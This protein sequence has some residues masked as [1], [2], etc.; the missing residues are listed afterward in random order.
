MLSQAYGIMNRMGTES[1]R[2]KTRYSTEETGASGDDVETGRI[3]IKRSPSGSAP[4]GTPEEL[5]TAYEAFENDVRNPSADANR[6][7]L[8]SLF[9]DKGDPRRPPEWFGRGLLYTAI[10]VFSAIFVWNGWARIQLIVTYVLIAVFI[11]LAVEPVVLWLI[12]HGWKRSVASVTALLSV[13]LITCAMLVLFGQMFVQQLMSMF[14]NLPSLYMQ[15]SSDIE[16]QFHFAMPEIDDL[17]SEA[18]AFIKKT[19]ISGYAG[20]AISTLTSLVGGI[21]GIA[22]V[23]VISFY[24]SAAGPKLRKSLCKWLSPRTQR[25]FLYTWTVAQDQISNFLYSRIILA[26]IAAVSVSLFLLFVLH[27]PY[28][29]PLAIFFG[30]MSQFIPTVGTYIGL[31]VPLLSAWLNNGMWGAVGLVAFVTAYTQVKNLI[32]APRISQRTM[33]LNACISFLSVLVFTALFGPVGGFLG[34]PLAAS[35]K[36]IFKAYTKSYDLIDSDLL[37]DPKAKK[38]SAVVVGAE[39]IGEHVIKPVVSKFPRKVSGSSARVTEIDED[40]AQLRNEYI[41]GTPDSGK[42]GSYGSG[43][44]H[45]SAYGETDSDSETVAIPKDIMNRNARLSASKKPG[46]RVGAKFDA[47]NNAQSGTKSGRKNKIHKNTQKYADNTENSI[48]N[49]EN[50]ENKENAEKESARTGNPRERWR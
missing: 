24:V 15:L 27:N 29:L 16:N 44:A 19:D 22:T 45:N 26:V 18:L 42:T 37:D 11:A 33:E 35:I 25:K 5:E 46:K 3:R 39:A 50:A 20:Q 4:A 30:L 6:L 36:V 23:L 41:Y 31:A 47:K 13:I 12:R 32:L 17:G 9:P 8:A 2:H 43:S 49:T 7:D 14:S 21:F 34:L 40:L 48:E 28:W 10:G 1:D 38:K